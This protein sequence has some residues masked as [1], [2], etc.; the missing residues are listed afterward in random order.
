ML[1]DKVNM[2]LGI[3]FQSVLVKL[4]GSNARN[5]EANTEIK[6]QRLHVSSPQAVPPTERA[7]GLR[8]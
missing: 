1:I 8:C 7:A 3:F 6:H 5:A 2:K 4:Q